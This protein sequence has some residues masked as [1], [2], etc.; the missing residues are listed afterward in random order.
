MAQSV[1]EEGRDEDWVV[2]AADTV[3]RVVGTV[4][5]KTTV[6][7]TTAARALVYGIVLAVAGVAGLVLFTIG[8]VRAVDV[9]VPGR[10]WWAY[11]VVGLVF[12]FAGAWLWS[13]RTP[14]ASR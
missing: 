5:S 12:V 6:R 7:I 3:E 13:K 14:K 4:R 9:Y 2:Q 1:S 11:L 10:V 8:A